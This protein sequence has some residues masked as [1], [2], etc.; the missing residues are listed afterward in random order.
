MPDGATLQAF[1]AVAGT[2]RINGP[3]AHFGTARVV[4]VVQ[5]LIDAPLIP[6]IITD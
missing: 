3:S 1:A 5:K 2:D 6:R 4:T